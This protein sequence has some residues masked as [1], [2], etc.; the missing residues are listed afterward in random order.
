MSDNMTKPMRESVGEYF[1]R[2]ARRFPMVGAQSRGLLGRLAD[3]FLRR[4]L[5][6]RYQRTLDLCT[7]A[8]GRTVLDIGCGVG[9]YAVALAQRGATHVTGI[10]LS[11]T[12]LRLAQERATEAGVENRCEFIRTDLATFTIEQPFDLVIAMGVLDYVGAAPSF[13]EK[14]VQSARVLAVFSLPVR[15]GFLARQRRVRYR[16]RCPLFMYSRADLDQMFGV[17]DYPY[18]VE[19]LARDWFVTVWIE[20]RATA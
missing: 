4:S 9:T 17:L 8:D 13:I 15:D 11:E 5:R 2:E 14:A 10:D 1:E 20:P 12:M 19:R 18:N 6:L 16:R 7:P 3:R